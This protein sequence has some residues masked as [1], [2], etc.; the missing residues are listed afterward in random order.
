MESDARE[1]VR[2]HLGNETDGYL[3]PC[4]PPFAYLLREPNRITGAYT[5]KK[6]GFITFDI[7]EPSLH[8]IADMLS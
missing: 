6:G 2:N 3:Y 7:V 8:E 4:P 5:D 1:R